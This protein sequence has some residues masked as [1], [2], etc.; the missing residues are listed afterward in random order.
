MKRGVRKESKKK[1]TDKKEKK[2]F[3]HV[4]LLVT[5][6][7]FLVNMVFQIHQVT[8]QRQ[9]SELWSLHFHVSSLRLLRCAL[10]YTP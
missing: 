1:N 10:P 2:T 6:M 9:K 4:K 7:Q 5:G 3:A 8:Q